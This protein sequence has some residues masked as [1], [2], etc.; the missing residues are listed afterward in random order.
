[1]SRIRLRPGDFVEVELPKGRRYLRYIGRYAKEVP[2]DVFAVLRTDHDNRPAD[3][4]R[5]ELLGHAYLMA[6]VCKVLLDDARF[7]LVEGSRI[8]DF[9]MP[10]FRERYGI[11]WHIKNPDGDFLVRELDATSAALP[12]L[13]LV[14]PTEI[15]GRLQTGWVP[16]D[17]TV[18]STEWFVNA[19]SRARKKGWRGFTQVEWDIELGKNVDRTS[20]ARRL[21]TISQ[22]TAVRESDSMTSILLTIVAPSPADLSGP[23][24]AETEGKIGDAIKGMDASIAGH[25]IG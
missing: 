24:L 4:G 11:G 22:D 7:R 19:V 25:E 2:Y 17:D 8:N 16:Q 1:L 18:D 10:T 20:L 14:P 23:W 6:S 5:L 12:I 3:A 21:K 9:I 15:I 13:E